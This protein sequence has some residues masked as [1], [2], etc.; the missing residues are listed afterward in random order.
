MKTLSEHEREKNPP[1]EKAWV[2]VACDHC[3]NELYNSTPDIVLTTFP[4]KINVRC[5][6]CGFIGFM[7][8]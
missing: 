1:K 8:K 3:G 7:T 5:P 4:P 2:G 6:N